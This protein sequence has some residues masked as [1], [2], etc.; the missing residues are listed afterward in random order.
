M[1][2]EK[3]KQG[4]Y[5]KVTGWFTHPRNMC[6]YKDSCDLKPD[7]EIAKMRHHELRAHLIELQLLDEGE[8][9]MKEKDTRKVEIISEGEPEKKKRKKEKKDEE[10]KEK[11][12]MQRKEE[13]KKRQEEEAARKKAKEEEEKKKKEAEESKESLRGET[14]SILYGYHLTLT[15]GAPRAN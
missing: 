7:A 11:E 6:N 15:T 12:E 5:A 2:Q 9:K 4:D 8:E 14:T 10:K 3:K 13:E 1:R